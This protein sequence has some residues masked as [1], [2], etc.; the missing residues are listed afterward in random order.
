M[1]EG[2][3]QKRVASWKRVLS[4]F[5]MLVWI[6]FIIWPNRSCSSGAPA[7]EGADEGAGIG[8]VFLAMIVG[9]FF[10]GIGVAGYFLVVGTQCFTFDFTGPFWK[11][12]KVKLY[13]ANIIIPLLLILGIG[14][15]VSMFVTP[16][17][18]TFGVST[19]VAFLVP[20]FTML[21]VVQLFLI[22]FGIWTPMDKKIVDKRLAALGVP[23]GTIEYG[24]YVG[25]SNPDRSSF[26]KF[27][28]IEEDVGILWIEPDRLVYMG[29]DMR[30]EIGRDQLVEVQRKA[31]AGS[32][33]SVFG[34]AVHVILRIREADGSE[35]RVRLHPEGNWTLTASAKASDR[36]ATL[37]TNWQTPTDT[38]P[39]L[40]PRLSSV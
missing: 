32:S 12:F 29:D 18:T 10:F 38:P 30:L 8:H 6:G 19:T 28:A 20:I 37:I 7:E 1:A 9:L 13:F 14:F 15:L 17:L 33:A 16:I 21:V 22:W 27:G 24:H 23:S 25:I 11:S 39:P 2:D 34:G 26:K 3:N 35:R 31:D 4:W 40:P 36:L 5:L